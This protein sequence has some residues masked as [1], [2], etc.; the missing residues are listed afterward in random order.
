MDACGIKTYQRKTIVGRWETHK[1]FQQFHVNFNIEKILIL[2][3][4]HYK[5]TFIYN[6]LIIG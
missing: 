6:A 2:Q 5:S 3:W 4:Q 1:P